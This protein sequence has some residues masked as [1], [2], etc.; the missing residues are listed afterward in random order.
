MNDS[1]SKRKKNEQFMNEVSNMCEDGREIE[2]LLI[3]V[4]NKIYLVLNITELYEHQFVMGLNGNILLI[5]I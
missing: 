4:Y 1:V 3:L 5:S 2:N